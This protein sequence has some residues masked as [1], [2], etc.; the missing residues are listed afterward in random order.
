MSE[1]IGFWASLI[2]G[3][4]KYETSFSPLAWF[5]HSDALSFIEFTFHIKSMI[6][7]IRSYL[8]TSI[9]SQSKVEVFLARGCKCM[10]SVDIFLKRY[11]SESW[12]FI[13]TYGDMINFS[14]K[15]SFDRVYIRFYF[16]K[17]VGNLTLLRSRIFDQR[18]NTCFKLYKVL[19][20]KFNLYNIY[21]VR[22][23]PG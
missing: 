12:T 3:W 21:L 8:V 1:A 23:R 16:I 2:F 9:S 14:S 22:I 18:C 17:S 15:S 7:W 13:E 19:T 20:R 4:R 5:E 11:V 6:F 10:G